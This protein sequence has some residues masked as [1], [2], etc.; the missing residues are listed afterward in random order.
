MNSA[1][2]CFV[3]YFRDAA[4]FNWKDG[5][6]KLYAVYRISLHASSGNGWPGNNG[7]GTGVNLTR[8]RIDDRPFVRS[9][10]I[11]NSSSRNLRLEVCTTCS[12]A[13]NSFGGCPGWLAGYEKTHVF[14][15]ARYHM[16]ANFQSAFSPVAR[17][18]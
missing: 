6:T 18:T 2:E 9:R 16:P 5:V 11:R 14:D 8:T 12:V 17:L 13:P 15:P 10:G 7:I 4:Y 3:A 1:N